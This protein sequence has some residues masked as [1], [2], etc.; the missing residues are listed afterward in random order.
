MAIDQVPINN[1][2]FVKLSKSNI[3]YRKY[4]TLNIVGTYSCY[5]QIVVILRAWL[6]LFYKEYD[7]SKNL[8]INHQL[9]Y[10]GPTLHDSISFSRS[11]I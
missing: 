6:Q 3:K 8:D 11:D 1:S 9:T 10:L 4:S 5:N 7:W 2:S